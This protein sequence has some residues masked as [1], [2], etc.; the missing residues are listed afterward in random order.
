MNTK[1]NLEIDLRDIIGT[2][3]HY[4]ED[5]DEYDVTD[6]DPAEEFRK[7]IAEKAIKHIDAEKRVDSI[8]DKMIVRRVQP[9][10]DDRINSLYDDLINKEINITDRYGETSFSGTVLG[11]LKENFDN[12]LTERV[13]SKGNKSTSSYNTYT[14]L[15]F[16][17]DERLNKLQSSFMEESLKKVNQ[18]METYVDK[19]DEAV[20][21]QIKKAVQSRIG[22]KLYENLDIGTLIENIK[23][24]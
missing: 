6:K 18:S 22:E 20:K 8:I 1:I 4:D 3:S 16:I 12:F 13:D 15:E 7:I 19:V 24:D 11:K 5:G 17:I 9:L 14:R 23:K 2:I 21:D 10:I